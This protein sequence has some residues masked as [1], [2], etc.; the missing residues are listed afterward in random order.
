MRRWSVAAVWVCRAL[1]QE[2]VRAAVV[3]F[4][5]ASREADIGAPVAAT[6]TVAVL[7]RQAVAVS[8][9][10]QGCREHEQQQHHVVSDDCAAQQRG[11]HHAYAVHWFRLANHGATCTQLAG[12]PQRSTRVPPAARPGAADLGAVNRDTNL[13]FQSSDSV[14]C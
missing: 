8:R 10:R 9:T 4:G 1:P 5:I 6:T 14:K 7:A 3:V 12:P 13:V 2:R 11:P